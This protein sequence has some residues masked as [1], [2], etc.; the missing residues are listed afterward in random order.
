MDDFRDY[1]Y[2]AR[3]AATGDRH[4]KSCE[5]RETAALIAASR[6]PQATPT[7]GE[8]TRHAEVWPLSFTK[9]LPHDSDGFVDPKAFHAFVTAI[10]EPDRP[11][12]PHAFDV[13]LGP[14]AG[15]APGGNTPYSYKPRPEYAL[16]WRCARRDG[17]PLTVRAWESPRA[18]HVYDL[19]GADA[20]DIAMDAAPALGS[21]ELTAEMA[22]VY[23]LAL[24]RDVP[25]SEISAGGTA[26]APA[27]L[28]A[29]AAFTGLGRLAFLNA[30]TVLDGLTP[31]QA[32][33]R[34]ARFDQTG[35]FTP[36]T[37]FRG[38]TPGAQTGPYLSQFLLV[39][40]GTCPQETREGLISYGANTIDQRVA[41]LAPGVDHMVDF[42]SWFDVQMGADIKD[43][44]TADA[45]RRFITTPRQLASYVRVDQL[46]Q[47]YLNAALV[48]LVQGAGFDSGFPEGTGKSRA[49][50]AT[51]GGPHML[52]LISEVSSRALKAVRR[53][54]FNIHRRG[55]PERLA[56]M[57]DKVASGAPGKL[58]TAM[59]AQL[60]TMYLNLDKAGLMAPVAAHNAAQLATHAAR[61]GSYPLTGLGH[62]AALSHLLPMAFI[63]G[64]PMHP[65]YGAGHAT[66]A[67]ACVTVLKAFFEMFT[68]PDGWTERLM[69]SVGLG[70][71]VEPNVVADG[72]KVDFDRSGTK[73]VDATDQTRLTIQGELDKLAANIAIGRDM[74]GVHFYTDYYES[75][76]LGERMAVTILQEQMLT[77]PEPVSM[78]FVSYDGDR[79]LIEGTGH[80]VSVTIFGKNGRPVDYAAWLSRAAQAP[81]PA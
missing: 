20:S 31:R 17:A 1:D 11:G 55:R 43:L 53:Q 35:A 64:S 27:G 69:D 32:D 80:A 65:S 57:V 77:Y 52:A 70:C 44:Q 14:Q 33:R 5:I 78:R 18:G 66:V 61:D 63:E 40:T 50:F 59:R 60:R 16:G 56:A 26:F 48:L 73:L 28:S 67:G 75:L 6:A 24:L 46:Y 23:A 3:P 54:K 34:A 19:Q 39:G 76:R 8:E 58:T 81:V 37:M 47:A 79:V 74:A 7:N 45:G 62:E 49:A 42:N 51:F 21:E 9:G 25:F 41:S 38:S 71:S 13:P 36:Q 29:H 4:L 22:E 12:L 2:L 72:A 30:R 68:T 10:T 15:L